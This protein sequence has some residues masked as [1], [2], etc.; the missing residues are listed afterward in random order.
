MNSVLRRSRRISAM[1][2]DVRVALAFSGL[3]LIHPPAAAQHAHGVD[4]TPVAHKGG[5]APHA[6]QGTISAKARDQIV[7]VEHA[8]ADLNTVDAARTAGFLPI[9][10]L[11]PTMGEHWVNVGRVLDTVRLLQPPQLLFSPVGGK[12]QLVGI[13]YSFLGQKAQAPD[14]FDGELDVWHDHPEL[15][16]Q[17]KS[18][19]MLHVWFVPSPQGPFAGQNP[20][21]PYWAAGVE[22][23]ADSVL[24]VPTS[25]LRARQLGLAL[26]EA[27]EPFGLIAQVRG[28]ASPLQMAIAQAQGNVQTNTDS[29]LTPEIQARRDSLRTAIPLLNAARQ[30]GDQASWDREADQ[31]IAV[32]KRVRDAYLETLPPKPRDGM[33]AF[34][35]TME[36]EGHEH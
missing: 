11:I 33:A 3:L 16:P 36:K 17:G 30:A 20:W 8:V 1:S 27:M 2:W 23:P 32:W 34:Y 4:A 15:G 7:S 21:L 5:A 9:F 12:P 28:G 13:A 10:G 24:S 14:L 25:A 18:A 19:V 29:A 22:P 6:G 35:Q 26:A 31:T